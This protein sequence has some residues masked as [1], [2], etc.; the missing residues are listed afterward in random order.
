[1]MKKITILYSKNSN[2]AYEY[3]YRY[4]DI[5]NLLATETNPI[6]IKALMNY[7]NYNIGDHR[8][9]LCLLEK[10]HFEKFISKYKKTISKLK[11]I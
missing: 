7:E 5:L 9:P 6:A 2:L 4:Y 1:M 3:F 8:L 10:E 11:I